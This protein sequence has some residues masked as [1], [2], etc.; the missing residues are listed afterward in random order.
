LRGGSFLIVQ[1]GRNVHVS[2]YQ[3]RWTED[4]SVS[5][6]IERT[7]GPD[8]VVSARLQLTDVDGDSGALRIVWREGR[9]PALANISGRIGALAVAAA[10]PAP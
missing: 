7:P 5:G 1:H 10:A 3:V 4:V 2:L 9:S 6:A 8:G